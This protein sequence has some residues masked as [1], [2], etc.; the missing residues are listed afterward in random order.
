M[1]G[2]QLGEPIEL[3]LGAGPPRRDSLTIASG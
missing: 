2:Q 1:L 3:P